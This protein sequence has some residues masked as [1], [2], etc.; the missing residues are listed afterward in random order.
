M[1]NALRLPS[2]GKKIKLQ[3]VERVEK[4]TKAEIQEMMLLVCDR[5]ISNQ[6]YLCKLDAFVGDGDH[7]ITA[8]RGFSVVKDHLE[9]KEYMDIGEMME[10]ISETL[11]EA[12][13]GAIG[14]IFGAVFEGAGETVQGKQEITQVEFAEFWKGA[15]NNVMEIGGANVGDRTL[16]DCLSPAVDSLLKYSGNEGLQHM[17]ERAVESAEKGTA[18]TKNMEA[19]KGRAKFLAEKSIGY[20]D[21]GATSMLIIFKGCLE[22]C[23]QSKDNLYNSGGKTCLL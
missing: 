5:I 18:A 19:R 8:A 4:L 22:F 21:A 2:V 10:D 7:G 1:G 20:Q 14:P 13:G 3:K 9:D 16:V 11:S 17:L 15:L 6:E 23:R 12:M